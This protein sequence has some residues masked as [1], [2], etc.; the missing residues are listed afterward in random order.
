M[1]IAK[2][3]T[4]IVGYSL[5]VFVFLASVS[6]PADASLEPLSEIELAQIWAKNSEVD[7]PPSVPK[8]QVKRTQRVSSQVIET[9]LRNIKKEDVVEIALNKKMLKFAR[10]GADIAVQFIK[11]LGSN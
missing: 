1:L 7:Q 9:V 11:I 6:V 10:N 8:D 2:S 4:K 5:F 3:I